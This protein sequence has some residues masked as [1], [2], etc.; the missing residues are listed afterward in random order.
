VIAE[1]NG[2]YEIVAET[3][4]IGQPHAWLNP[5][6]IA[7]FDGDGKID[8]ALVRMPHVLGTLELWTWADKRLRKLAEL[9]DTANH[10]AGTRA[11]AMSAAADFDGDGI[12]DLAVPS[13]D[14]SRLHIISF[15]PTAREIAGVALPAK[16]VT[17]I[18]LVAVPSG[19]P[20]LVAGL[21]DGSLVVIRRD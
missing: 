2:R 12:A 20:A 4:P 18:A 13:L 15:A 9:A 21:A 14:R 19:P 3:P 17:N 8:I 6:G 1:R 10:V 5:A 16:V 7:D 11:I